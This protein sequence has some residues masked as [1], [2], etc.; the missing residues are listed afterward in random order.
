MKNIINQTF[1]ANEDVA[2]CVPSVGMFMFF[3]ERSNYSVAYNSCASVGGNLAH[4]VSEVRNIELSKLLR[5]STNSSAKERAAYVG[6]NET[7][8]NKF[9]TSNNEPLGCFNFRAWAPGH[10]PEV[11]RPSCV[12]VTPES[13][14]K[15]FNCNRKLMFICELLTSGPNPYVKNLLQKCSI[16]RPNN[17]FISSKSSNF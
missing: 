11:R 9:F 5:I 7:V 10:P 14:W 8:S 17:R 13:N 6:L 1:L 2:I 15:V 12:G 3:K 16:E 4:I